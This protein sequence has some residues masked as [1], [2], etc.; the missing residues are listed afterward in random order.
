MKE[1]KK[2]YITKRTLTRAGKVSSRR[3]VTKLRPTP[4]F[5]RYGVFF[6]PLLSS[7]LT[8]KVFSPSSLSHVDLQNRACIRMKTPHMTAPL[9]FAA[10]GSR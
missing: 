7:F 3:G 2:Q 8:H 5:R 1:K 4:I 9:L 6:S 10:A